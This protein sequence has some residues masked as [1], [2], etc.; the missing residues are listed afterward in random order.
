MTHQHQTL[1]QQIEAELKGL[2]SVDWERVDD[3]D[4][5]EMRRNMTVD[6]IL[7]L[8]AKELAALQ[9]QVEYRHVATD[10]AWR[11]AIHKVLGGGDGK[12]SLRTTSNS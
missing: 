11:K 3:P 7:T 10:K 4:R 5:E 8:V 12:D 9:P 2:L 6:A 1:R